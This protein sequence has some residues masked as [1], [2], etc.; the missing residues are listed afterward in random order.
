[1]KTTDAS[2]ADINLGCQKLCKD[3]KCKYR[4]NLEGFVTPS[5][6]DQQPVL[7]IEELYELGKKKDVCPFYLTRNNVAG[8]NIILDILCLHA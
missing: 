1:V 8:E 2:A 5:N 3:R 6:A 7:D 4:N